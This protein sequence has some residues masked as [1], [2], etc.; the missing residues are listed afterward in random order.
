MAI[1]AILTAT[2]A[3]ADP[4][5]IVVQGVIGHYHHTLPPRFKPAPVPDLNIHDPRP[6]AG[7]A[8]LRPFGGA[9]RDASPMPSFNPATRDSVPPIGSGLPP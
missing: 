4:P 6:P 9:Y 2:G 3:R 1:I 7:D 5:P 8:Y